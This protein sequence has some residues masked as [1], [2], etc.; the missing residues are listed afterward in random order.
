MAASNSYDVIIIGTG[1]GGGTLLHALAPTG[2]R[3]LVLE[4]GGYLPREKD[5]WNSRAVFIQNKYKAPESWY[6]KEGKPFRPEIHYYVG[7]QTKLYGSALLRFHPKDFEQVSHYDGISP[8]WPI[9]YDDLAPYYA[10]AERLYHVHSDH[11]PYPALKHE[12]RIQE[13]HDDL[14]GLGYSPCSLPMGIM[15]NEQDPENSKCIRCNTCDGYPCLI[16]GKADAEVVCVNPALEHPNVTL[17]THTLVKR[18][19]SSASGREVT[20]VV[21]EYEGERIEF[22]GDIVVVS[23]GAINSAALLLRSASEAHPNGLANSSDN[24]GRNYMCHNNSVFVWLSPQPNPTSFEKTLALND[25]Y[26]GSDDSTYPLGAIQTMGKSDAEK[27]EAGSP[28]P[29]PH[30]LLDQLAKHSLDFWLTSEDLPHPDNRIIVG[31][32]G[33]I[34]I[35]YEQNNLEAHDRLNHK[36]SS[37]LRQIE[38]KHSP[39]PLSLSLRKKIPIRGVT[40]QCGTLRFGRDPMTSVLDINCKAHDVSNLYVVDGSFMPSSAAMNPALTIFANALRVG[41]YLKAILD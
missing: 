40:H 39:V 27:F 29:L 15:L 32:D 21:A 10:A 31:K 17:L 8:A 13:L 38:A 25:F 23:C 12:P 35:Q 5:N 37:L 3:I 26:L 28:V 14:L 9:S 36:L 6:D 34:G 41:D 4:R 11:G 20:S 7:G 30:A 22:R 2:K 1:A 24:V 16:K 33:A 18:L 19:K